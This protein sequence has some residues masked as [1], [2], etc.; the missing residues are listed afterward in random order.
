M[1]FGR[2]SALSVDRAR[3]HGIQQLFALE[4]LALIEHDAES[5]IDQ[6][7][8]VLID[9]HMDTA[10]LRAVGRPELMSCPW[11]MATA[12]WCSALSQAAP[13]GC[14]WTPDRTTATRS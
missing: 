14:S 10:L 3:N 8:P 9:V 12:C 5:V 13:G 11:P 7:V 1:W 6:I 2:L 4:D